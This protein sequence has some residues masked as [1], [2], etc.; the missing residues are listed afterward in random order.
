LMANNLP[1]QNFI[2]DGY[3][4]VKVVPV[5]MGKKQDNKSQTFITAKG[6]IWLSQFV[7]L[8]NS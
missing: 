8:P 3:F 1:Y 2:D 7:S 4:V 6:L 5:K